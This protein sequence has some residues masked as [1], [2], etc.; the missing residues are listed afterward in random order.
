MPANRL[1]VLKTTEI[2]QYVVLLG[3]F[4]LLHTL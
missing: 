2:W 1:W 4:N 3:A